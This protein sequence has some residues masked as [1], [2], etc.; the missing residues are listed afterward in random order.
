MSVPCDSFRRC[1]ALSILLRTLHADV[2]YTVVVNCNEGLEMS[3]WLNSGFE[4]AGRYYGTNYYE[5]EREEKDDACYDAARR[6]Q[7]R[8]RANCENCWT[9][10]T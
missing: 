10:P 9:V 5:W 1:C 6:R 4:R 7:V 3:I 8:T 2:M